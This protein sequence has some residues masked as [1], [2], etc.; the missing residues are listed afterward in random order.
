V[1]PSPRCPTCRGPVPPTSEALPFCSARCQ[2]VDLGRWLG[3]E[4]RIPVVEEDDEEEAPPSS[5]PE[6][7]ATPAPPGSV[8]PLR[9]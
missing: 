7:P 9:N 2:L 8:P 3:E 6:A 4:Y 1:T 5:R